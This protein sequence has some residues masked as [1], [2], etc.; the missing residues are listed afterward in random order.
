MIKMISENNFQ[1]IAKQVLHRP[2]L[3]MSHSQYSEVSEKKYF[4]N[5][6]NAKQALICRAKWRLG[7]MISSY[8]KELQIAIAMGKIGLCKPTTKVVIGLG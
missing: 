4:E 7:D 3:K 1:N 2:F 8:C 5:K 6:N